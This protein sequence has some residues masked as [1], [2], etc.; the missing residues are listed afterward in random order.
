MALKKIIEWSFVT[1]AFAITIV[2]FI[3]IVKTFNVL[4]DGIISGFIGF[5]GSII[6]GLFTLWGVNR[7]LEVQRNEK[8]DDEFVGK[9]SN[10]E[11]II[12]QID[13]II[14][15]DFNFNIIYSTLW[16]AYKRIKIERSNPIFTNI[17]ELS[18]SVDG[19]TYRN[20]TTMFVEKYFLVFD[21]CAEYYDKG[22]H[23]TGKYDDMMNPIFKIDKECNKKVSETVTAYIN[24]LT[25]LKDKLIYHKSQLEKRFF[26][27]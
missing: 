26:N 11:I 7:T 22:R 18:K 10:L 16:E 17:I 5:I 27:H 1:L 9:M 24:N 3:A 13:R 15:E 14:K 6:G 19:E 25:L 12:E 20:L 4:S 21:E 23:S 2:S 8:F